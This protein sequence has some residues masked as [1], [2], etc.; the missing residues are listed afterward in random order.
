MKEG[1]RGT[2]RKD[3]HSLRRKPVAAK[4]EKRQ[5]SSP[6]ILGKVL[7]HGV[8]LESVRERTSRGSARTLVE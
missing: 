7:V 3:S 6:K 5:L 4:P 2:L 1:R 8:L